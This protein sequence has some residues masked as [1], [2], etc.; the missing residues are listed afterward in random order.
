MERIRASREALDLFETEEQL[1]K[2]RGLYEEA[3]RRMAGTEKVVRIDG[4]HSAELVAEAVRRAVEP[5]L[6]GPS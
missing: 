5:L 2:V 6:P 3:F 4:N 1:R